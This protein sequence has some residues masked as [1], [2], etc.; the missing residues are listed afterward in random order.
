MAMMIS[1]CSDCKRD[2]KS[3]ED[4]NKLGHFSHPNN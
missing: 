2:A 4:M 3:I 1:I